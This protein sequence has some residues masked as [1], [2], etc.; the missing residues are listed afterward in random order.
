MISNTAYPVLLLCG[1]DPNR[2]D[3]MKV[4]DPEGLLPSKALLPMAGKRVLDWQLDAM[5]ES[6]DIGDIY[7]IGLSPEE[8]PSDL[9]LK[10]IQYERNSS[11]LEKIKY[12]SLFLQKAYP[13]LDHVIVCSGDAPGVT[14]SSIN[15][16]F[17]M[18]RQ[19]LD[20]DLLIGV[21]PEDITLK[22]FPNHRRVIGK[23]KDL[24]VYPGEMYVFRHKIIPVI[25]DEILQM[26]LKRRQFDRQKD[27]SK[28]VPILKYL[29][30]KPRLWLLIIKYGLGLLSIS[31]LES[32]LS[33]VYNLKMKAIIIPDPGF[34]MDLDL[35]EDYESIT[36]Y[37]KMTKVQAL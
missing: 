4:L 16:F 17:D 12:G 7:L 30:R 25:E 2:R 27:T 36:E 37:I 9:D 28:L 1:C 35:P 19:N 11:I 20:A 21:V 24:S 6:P 8:F 23:F 10:Y 5:I 14:T 15:Q 26:T 3:L 13:D 22:F 29:G 32:I 33:K 34:G 31:K 18:F